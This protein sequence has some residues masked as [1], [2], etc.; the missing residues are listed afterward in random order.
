M[1]FTR[2]IPATI[3]T[4]FLG[5]GKTTTIRH[6]LKNANGRRL[7]F[8]INE[9]GDLGIDGEIVKGCGIEGCADE[10]VLELTNG[11]ICCTVAD[12]FLPSIKTLLDRPHP[13]DHI[14]I[15]TS[16]LA[17]PKPLVKAFSWPEV[18]ARVTVDG[19]VALVDGPAVA[20]GLFAN[21]AGA[22]DAQRLAD[23]GLSHDTPLEELFEEQ[24]A[25]ADLIM[26]NKSDLIREAD[27]AEVM[28]VINSHKRA[29]ARVLVTRHGRIDPAILLG[30]EAAAEDD[31]ASRPSHH[32]GVEGHDH[33]DFHSFVATIGS[34]ARPEDLIAKIEALGA[35]HDVLRIKGFADI[36]GKPMRLVIQGV[37]P[38]LQH[39]YDRPWADSEPRVTRLVVIGEKG[40]DEAAICSLLQE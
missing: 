28:A 37:G 25:C 32:D 16:G 6:L 22:I 14:V 20:D 39:Y 10:D 2:K 24:L 35:A 3:L 36:K 19:V 23:D 30:L 33:D 1:E 29:A 7:A 15:E 13:P 21:N 34:F 8:I 17:M 26:L 18:K 11:C 27:K 38:R 31:L 9:F 4:G 12:D 5:A 40:I